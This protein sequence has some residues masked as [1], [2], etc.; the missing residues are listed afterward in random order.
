MGHA[1]LRACFRMLAGSRWAVPLMPLILS[2]VQFDPARS[3]VPLIPCI[4]RIAGILIYFS[5][6]TAR[7]TLPPA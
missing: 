4:A 7:L 6:A 3:S 2:R 5:V 1:A